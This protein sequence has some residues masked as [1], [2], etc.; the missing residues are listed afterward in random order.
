M[1]EKYQE[2]AAAVAAF[3]HAEAMAAKWHAKAAFL[4]GQILTLSDE[5]AQQRTETEPAPAEEIVP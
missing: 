5:V 1:T 4:D 2:L 3:R